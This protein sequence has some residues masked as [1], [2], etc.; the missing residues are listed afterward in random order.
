MGRRQV[1]KITHQVTSVRTYW[2][3]KN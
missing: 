1:Y 2:Y 3:E